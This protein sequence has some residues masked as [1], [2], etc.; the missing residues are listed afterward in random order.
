M[1]ENLKLGLF[2]MVSGFKKTNNNKKKAKWF[3]AKDP[4]QLKSL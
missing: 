4:N 2:G 3:L 1:F